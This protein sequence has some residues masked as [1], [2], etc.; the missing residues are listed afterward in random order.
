MNRILLLAVIILPFLSGPRASAQQL[1]AYHFTADNQ[2]VT[3]NVPLNEISTRA[4]RQFIKAYGFVPSAVWRKEEQGYAVRWFDRD[5]IGYVVHYTL[6]G[7]L[8]DTH[9]YYTP[10]NA[11]PEIRTQ[12]GRLYP[13][14]DLL[15]VN[16]LADAGHPLYEVGLGN[17]RLMLIVDVK[18]ASVQEEQYFVAVA[19][20]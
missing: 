19:S 3:S 17:Q 10:R 4:F 6:R 5:S 8:S 9:I 15:F 7:A 11:P 14:Y 16:E 13:A 12:M 1:I 2:D 18:D 20:K